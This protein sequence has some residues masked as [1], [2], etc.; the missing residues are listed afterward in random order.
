MTAPVLP[1]TAD[2]LGDIRPNREPDRAL[3]NRVH[4]MDGPTCAQAS[5]RGGWVCTRLPGH[6]GQ[7]IATGGALVLAVWTGTTM[8]STD[9]T[10]E[11][12]QTYAIALAAATGP[13]APAAGT[14]VHDP[15]CQVR[16]GDRCVHGE[17]TGFTRE[18]R[19]GQRDNPWD[20]YC[21]RQ[22]GHPGQHLAGN[23]ES[24]VAAWLTYEHA[25]RRT[26][27]DT[28]TTHA[29]YDALI[30]AG[31][32]A[33]APVALPSDYVDRDGDWWLHINERHGTPQYAMVGGSACEEDAVRERHRERLIAAYDR[34]PFDFDAVAHAGL[35]TRYG[36][37]TEKPRGPVV[38]PTP[39]DPADVP[40]DPEAD[41]RPGARSATV[42]RAE[43][44]TRCE[45]TS[46]RQ[47]SRA[48]G[49]PGQH[50]T[51]DLLNGGPLSRVTEVWITVEG[52][53][54]RLNRES[55]GTQEDAYDTA[56]T[57]AGYPPS[58]RDDLRLPELA[59]IPDPAPTDATDEVKATVQ[60]A[61][62]EAAEQHIRALDEWTERFKRAVR[63]EVVGG[64][65]RGGW[66]ESGT[67]DVL[68]HLQL[69]LLRMPR[70]VTATV[71]LVVEE[72]TSS[73]NAATLARNTL[74]RTLTETE[75][76]V[77]RVRV[78]SIDADRARV[79]DIEE[80]AF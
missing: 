61:R 56:M 24:V 58:P 12:A 10:P 35:E 63:V 30:N 73:D 46:A 59:P 48:Q 17:T 18:Q 66:C 65:V 7:H 38:A 8:L 15:L 4:R 1:D 60:A 75:L 54:H 68:R 19:C 43:N 40:P 21:T 14:K 29:E 23:T 64:Q 33:T 62:L 44:E 71:T 9:Y 27:Y 55:T 45:A 49:H 34:D 5:P 6:P 67:M 2:P 47:C 72:S 41:T 77:D 78:E 32:S 36:P 51:A 26:E 79:A 53:T 70:R 20:V 74:K 50:I 13:G 42:R 76:A 80:L 25:I 37:L 28:D 22:K 39:V 11:Q 31:F 3:T 16:P 69:D 52:R 57:T